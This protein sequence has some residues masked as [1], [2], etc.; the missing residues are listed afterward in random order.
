MLSIRSYFGW[1]STLLFYRFIVQKF[2]YSN[3]KYLHYVPL[4][5]SQEGIVLDGEEVTQ[6]VQA[7]RFVQFAQG[8]MHC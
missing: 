6:A 1:N 3:I 5:H 8:K 2:P 4:G 7:D